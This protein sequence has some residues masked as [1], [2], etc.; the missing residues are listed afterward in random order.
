MEVCTVGGFSEVGKNMVALKHKEEVII[1]DMGLY[2]PPIL[3]LEEGEN[4]EQMNS[5]ELKQIGAIPND[6]VIKD[7]KGKAKAIV[8]SHCH[9]DHIGAIQDLAKRYNCPIYGTPYTIQVLRAMMKDNRKELP[10]KLIPLPTSKKVKLSKD[11]SFE[12]VH[13]T[14]STIQPAIISVDTPEG[15]VLYCNDFKLDDNP[16][17]GNKPDYNK[18]TQIAKKGVKLMFLEALYANDKSKHTASEKVAKQLLEDVILNQDHKDRAI[19]VTTF[20]S[21]LVRIGEVIKIAKKMKR[22]VLILGRSMGRYIQAAEDLRL[23]KYSANSRI[24]TYRNQ[25]KATLKDVEH[26]RGKYIVICTGNQAEPNSVLDRIT[27]GEFHFKFKERDSV[28]FSCRTIPTTETIER[29]SIME[30]ELKKRNVHVWT[31]VHVSGHSSKEDLKD[32]ITRMKPEHLIPS[33]GDQRME[34]ALEKQTIAHK[35]IKPENI[36]VMKDGDFL[37]I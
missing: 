27:K 26:N 4:R 10:N 31:D 12:L 13:I 36:H 25:I 5:R 24:K 34:K 37:K 17:F 3:N 21:H 19:F 15:I 9:L 29:R 35:L 18:L 1:L 11:L 20:A 8:L 33:H 30:R 16:G 28:V 14:H 6:D 7:W 2:L 22:E 32:F 23:V